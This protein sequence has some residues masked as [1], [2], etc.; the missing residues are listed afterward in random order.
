[1]NEADNGSAHLNE[2]QH[3]EQLGLP[4]AV[5]LSQNQNI[6]QTGS[7]LLAHLGQAGLQL[8]HRVHPALAVLHH[9]REEQREGADAHIGLGSAQSTVQYGR[10]ASREASL[11]CCLAWTNVVR[12]KN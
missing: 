4:S 3:V 1:M 10:L 9:L 11:H 7:H 8:G 12:K 2:Q 5:L 6:K